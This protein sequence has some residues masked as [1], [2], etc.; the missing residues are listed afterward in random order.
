MDHI[1]S[2]VRNE[3]LQKEGCTVSAWRKYNLL[4][5]YFEPKKQI[6]LINRLRLIWE[7][8]YLFVL[9]PFLDRYVI[10]FQMK[11]KKMN[12]KSSQ[13]I[14]YAHDLEKSKEFIKN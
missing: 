8:I 2:L 9:N 5:W 11:G 6:Y 7:D 1:S 12:F 4:F 3:R 10:L 13:I 14:L